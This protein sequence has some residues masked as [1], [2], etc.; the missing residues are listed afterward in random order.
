MANPAETTV[1]VQVPKSQLSAVFALLEAGA[2]VAPDPES[3]AAPTVADPAAVPGASSAANGLA[4]R[5]FKGLTFAHLPRP[6]R[7]ILAAWL[8][9][10]AGEFL[11]VTKLAGRIGVSRDQ[12]RAMISK[13]SARMKRTAKPADLE[14]KRT[15]LQLL[16]DLA[17]DEENSS[18]HRLTQAGRQAVE[19]YLQR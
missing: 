3:T 15:A 17:Y 9:L 1:F 2:I 7:E 19:R 8:G 16:V 13:L 4:D 18:S 14:D 11:P 6:Y 5:I 12:A 10:P